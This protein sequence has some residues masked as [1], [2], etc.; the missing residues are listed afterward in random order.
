MPSMIVV[1]ADMCAG[2]WVFVRL[3]NGAF[4]SAA[5]YKQFATGVT[6][7]RDAAVIAVDIPI[8]YPAPP[9]LERAADNKAYKMVG[10]RRNSVF[11]ALHPDVLWAP[12][13][14]TAHE[15]WCAL[16]GHRVKPLS[17]SLTKKTR[18]VAVIAPKNDRVY[19]VHPEVSFWA[20]ADRSP[21]FADH[22]LPAKKKWNGQIQRRALLA[23]DGIVIPDHLVNAEAAGA[24]DV[25]D[26]A[27]AAWSA[28]RIA[29]KAALSL[30]GP[31][32]P[33][34]NCQENGRQVAI[35]Y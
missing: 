22:P 26:A 10:P 14:K 15:R 7:S 12:D 30:P 35:W 29:A 31:P 4:Q 8:G 25:L 18:E 17:L 3:E 21:T 5:F 9:A 16:T 24:D 1:G 19:E 13:K 2:G 20:L 33:D 28:N 6:A 34:F 23:E 11:P 27:V 32:E